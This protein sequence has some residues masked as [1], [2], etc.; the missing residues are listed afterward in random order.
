MSGSIG[1]VSGPTCTVP[2]QFCICAVVSSGSG[3]SLSAPGNSGITLFSNSD[4][5]VLDFRLGGN[6]P[7]KMRVP[8]PPPEEKVEV[9]GIAGSGIF[10][11][12]GSGNSCWCMRYIGDSTWYGIQTFNGVVTELYFYQTGPNTFYLC[13][14]P[15]SCVTG[16]SSDC[17]TVTFDGLILA[18]Q[19]TTAIAYL[20]ISSCCGSGSGGSG[21]GGST[22]GGGGN[23]GCVS[24]LSAYQIGPMTITNGTCSNC[25]AYNALALSGCLHTLLRV[26][27]TCVWNDTC[28]GDACGVTP[29]PLYTLEYDTGLWTL[30]AWGTSPPGITPTVIASWTCPSGSFNCTG[31]STFNIST[32]TPICNG[33]PATILVS[34]G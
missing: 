21:S 30:K 7:D 8:S 26:G 24:V 11:S 16:V 5:L 15:G 13:S 19:A 29:A 6:D 10:G 25:N 31:T 12:G 2:P 17:Q 18:G 22:P 23:C 27:S 20:T 34:P 33:W 28:T 32:S 3:S 4:N 14:V 9:L 1:S